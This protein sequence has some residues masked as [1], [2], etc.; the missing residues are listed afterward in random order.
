MGGAGDEVSLHFTR[1]LP[2]VHVCMCV[3]VICVRAREYV[4]VRACVSASPT[5]MFDMSRR[6][7]SINHSFVRSFHWSTKELV[8]LV[9]SFF[10]LPV[11]FHKGTASNCA[12]SAVDTWTKDSWKTRFSPSM[13]SMSVGLAS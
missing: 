13:A 4:G 7:S 8:I 10:Y 11:L 12:T 2:L 6:P 9:V 3:C 5:S 1:G